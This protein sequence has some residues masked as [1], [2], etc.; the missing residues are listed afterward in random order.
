MPLESTLCPLS[1]VDKQEGNQ[2]IALILKNAAV[3]ELV[4]TL[5]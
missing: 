3:V 5:A 1:G 2:Y 4:D